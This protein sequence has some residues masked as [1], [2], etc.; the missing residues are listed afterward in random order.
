L[1]FPDD[2]GFLS[3][4][5]ADEE[6]TARVRKGDD[7]AYGI[8]AERYR[9]MTEGAVRRFEPSFAEL[10]DTSVWGEDDLRQCA[11]LALYRAAM[12]YD[13]AGKG[14]DVR[15]GL[16][17]KICVNN[18][19]ISELRKAGSEI[20][21]RARKREQEKNVPRRADPL[22]QLVTSEHF[23]SLTG[24]IRAALTPLERSVYDRYLA[25][26]SVEQIARALGR[27]SKSVSNA[28]YRMKIKIRGLLQND[29]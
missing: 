25:G 15:F 26:M 11:A 4:N 13:P 19:L 23:D 10:G 29:L 2:V 12:S 17:A 6:L 3:E 1:E 28:L 18:A 20:R 24:A 27:S 14:R 16:Y 5:P 21:R 7:A 9:P 8:L 22:E